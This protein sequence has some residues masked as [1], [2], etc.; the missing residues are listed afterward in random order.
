M[1]EAALEAAT[2]PVHRE[3]I[4][5]EELS[6][7]YAHLASLP[8][9]TLGRNEM[10]DAFALDAEMLGIRELFERRELYASFQCMKESRFA[11]HRDSVPYAVYRL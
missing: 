4:R 9:D 7:R 8:L 6:V 3:R 2:D 10:V 5:R 1:F 11:A